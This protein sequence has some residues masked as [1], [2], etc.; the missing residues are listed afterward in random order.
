M[1]SV[2]RVLAVSG[3]LRA[4]STNMAVLRTARQVAPESVQVIVYEGLGGLPQFNPDDDTDPL[5]SPVA[6]LRRQLHAAEAVLFSTPEYA[7]AMPGSFKNLLDWSIGD[8]QPG[9]IAGKPVA[10]IN[11]SPRGAANAHDAL[12]KV[13]GYASAVIVG[14]ACAEI[15]VTDAMLGSDGED[16]IVDSSARQRIADVVT[17]LVNHGDRSDPTGTTGAS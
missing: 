2:R 4:R 12:R 6:E 13:L 8:D 11:A 5:P 15:P 17:A 10:W 16:L 3:S 7:G 14:S 1:T 9:S